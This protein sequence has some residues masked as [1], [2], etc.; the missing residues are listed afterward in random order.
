MSSTAFCLTKLDDDSVTVNLCRTVT[1]SKTQKF[2]Y[3][4][5]FSFRYGSED[6]HSCLTVSDSD[7]ETWIGNRTL[8]VS[9]CEL[10]GGSSVSLRQ[11][12]GYWGPAPGN[13]DYGFITW[14][15]LVTVLQIVKK[16]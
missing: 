8:L 7:S 3:K 11:H 16:E 4:S 6:S 5:D 10:H 13:D 14:G 1:S 9:P 2:F 15:N 12:F